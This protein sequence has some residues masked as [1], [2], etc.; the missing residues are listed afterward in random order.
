MSITLKGIL[1]AVAPVLASALPGPLGNLARKVIG[2]VL[3][4]PDPPDVE[5]E[6][7]LAVANPELLLKLKEAD[8]K[9]RLDLE[10]LGIDL[11]RLAAEDRAGAR[12]MQIA[13]RNWFPPA[14]G[15]TVLLGWLAAFA[16]LIFQPL[17][18][19]NKD[20]IMLA[21]GTLNAGMMTVLAFYFG[22]S[23]S[24]RSKDDTIKKLSE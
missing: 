5:I 22:S 2:D 15:I 16:F 10:R 18:A 19:L 23:S 11:E 14:L 8:N 17:P 6:K 20:A 24:S 1:G 7:T 12:A 13:T 3:G 9:F 21:L 4:K